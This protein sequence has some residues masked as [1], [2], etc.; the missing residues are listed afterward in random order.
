MQKQISKVILP[1][2][3]L[4][5]SLVAFAPAAFAQ[6]TWSPDFDKGR[7]VYLDPALANDPSYPVQFSSLDKD[8]EQ[9][10]A[11]H[12][13]QIYVV[14]AR[15]GDEAVPQDQNWAPRTL[16]NLILKWQGQPGFPANEYLIILWLRRTDNPNK[17]WVAANGGNRLRGYGLD[18]ARF[19]D[20]N[21]PVIPALKRH[22]PQDPKGAMVEIADNVNGVI[23]QYEADQQ[24]QRDHDAFMAKLPYY[25][26]IGFLAAGFLG[27]I[28]WLSIRYRREKK[29]ALDA[30]GEWEPLLESAN[31]LY[32]KLSGSYLGFLQQQGDWETRFKNTT[33]AKYKQAVTDFADFSVRQKR[34]NNLLEEAKKAVARAFFPTVG[35]FRK[36]VAL[37]SSEPVEITG[38]E[39]PL[40]QATLFG[41]V[42][43]KT[44]YQPAKLLDSMEDL[45]KR[46]V[47]ALDSIIKAFEGA[48][49]D[50]KDIEGLMKDVDGAKEKLSQNGLSFEP[51]AARYTREKD[52]LQA[53]LSIL[54]SDPLSAF[55]GLEKV[56]ADL[57][58]L[59]ADLERA[60]SI[61]GSLSSAEAE[62]GKAVDKARTTREQKASYA[63]QLGDG[64]TAP[65]SAGGLFTLV[66]EAGNPDPRIAEA[67]QHLAAAL[68]AVVAG[69]LDKSDKE[70][71][72]ATDAARRAVRLVDSVLEAKTFVEKQVSM[73]RGNLGKL[74]A[75]VPD[76]GKA[77]SEL[78]SDFLAKNIAGEPDKLDGARG[79]IDATAGE[80]AKVKQAYDEQRFLAARG[81]LENIGGDI[82]SSRDKLVEIHARLATLRS[83]RQHSRDVIA[84]QSGVADALRSK[85]QANSFTTAAATDSEFE[86]LTKSLTAQKTDVAKDVTDW[87]AAAEAADHL[88]AAFQAVDAAI[89]QQKADHDRAVSKSEALR[90][91]IADA[92]SYV[93][94]GDT[95]QP[96]RSKLGE[97]KGVLS[98]MS[99]VLTRA[100]SDWA[101][102]GRRAEEGK[103]L[104]GKARELAQSDKSAANQARSSISR[105]SSEISSADRSYGRGVSADL[106]SARSQLGR[107]K[108]SLGSQSYE[109]ANREADSAYRAAQA[110]ASAAAAAVAAIIRREEEEERAR[111]RREEEERRRREE[112][113][114]SSSSSSSGGGSGGGGYSGG[115]GGGGYSGGSGGGGY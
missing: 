53:A 12:G 52:G 44:T 30:I 83:N 71:A 112:A 28:I 65:V 39:L 90:S 85:L 57:R 10:A 25:L 7:H 94:D 33:L 95:R 6:S 99:S 58:T 60:L 75:A 81:T 1:L 102:I 103:S 11:K 9:R 89:D 43:T 16:D 4:V 69:E 87:P 48:D 115:S 49:Q 36:A 21:G 14:A 70:K 45:F 114:R 76:A 31:A 27:L 26:L 50:K 40:D 61:K 113:S 3:A 51:Y 15:L 106:G 105:A 2:V 107:A 59:K 8:L 13:L 32:I 88:S 82:Q 19:S 56:E 29:L 54:A 34:A 77:V 100:K 38:K 84:A 55:D 109:D 37:L 62:I 22:M 80:L 93:N 101:S 78:K 110:A 108:S 63:Y 73:V 46:T 96:A 111:R 92:E 66:E 91:A 97:A 24:A 68:A 74:Q 67:R 47:K 17:G 64:E 42:V 18:G 5:L 98:E 79:V 20:P 104:A 23:D 35:G 86:R 72:A 41:G